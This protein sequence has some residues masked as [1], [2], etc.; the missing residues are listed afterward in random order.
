MPVQTIQLITGKIC[1]FGFLGLKSCVFD[2]SMQICDHLTLNPLALL[3][4]VN[5]T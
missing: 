2:Y 5:I 3:K 4:F 1:A